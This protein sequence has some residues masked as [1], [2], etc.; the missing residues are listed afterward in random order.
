MLFLSQENNI[1]TQ[2][3]GITGA[4]T[5]NT[6]AVVRINVLF[7]CI[8]AYSTWLATIQRNLEAKST[9]VTTK[10]YKLASSRFYSQFKSISN[11]VES[12][13]R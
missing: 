5:L 9:Q 1:H 7:T 4:L 3:A 2:T 13:P 12:I 11:M 6:F 10:L 8:T